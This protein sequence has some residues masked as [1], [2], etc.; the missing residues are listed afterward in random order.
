MKRFATILNYL[1]DQ[2]RYIF[3][4]FITNLLSILFSLISLTMLIPFLNILFKPEK[5][6][7]Q[8]PILTFS[9]KSALDY[10]NYVLGILINDYGP[11]YA[12]AAIC[13]IIIVSVFLKNLFLYLSI[14]VLAPMRSRVLNRIRADLYSKVLELPLGFFTEQRKGDLMSRMSNDIN[15]IEWSVISTLEGVFREPLTI[16]VIL[17]ALDFDESSILDCIR[18]TR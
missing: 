17:G 4:Y 7:H 1:R 9:A 6:I 5:I 3:L 8:K 14:R 10:L 15:E 12:L 11:V 16:L 13:V 18:M 2:K